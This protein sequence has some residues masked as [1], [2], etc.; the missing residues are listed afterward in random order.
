M[1]DAELLAVGDLLTPDGCAL[2]G[3]VIAVGPDLRFRPVFEGQEIFGH[4]CPFLC[5]FLC[6]AAYHN[7]RKINAV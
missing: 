3:L 7:F 6:C 4:G 5:C 2:H 1:F